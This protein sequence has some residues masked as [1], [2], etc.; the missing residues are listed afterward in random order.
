MKRSMIYAVQDRL[1]RDAWAHCR[2]LVTDPI[3]VG[4]EDVGSPQGGGTKS[5]SGKPLS[6]VQ[7]PGLIWNVADVLR[8]DQARSRLGS[9]TQNK[10]RRAGGVRET[11]G[12]D[13]VRSSNLI[14]Q[15]LD[16]IRAEDWIW[17]PELCLESVDRFRT[18]NAVGSFRRTW[19]ESGCRC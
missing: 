6:Q 7:Q 16:E 14:P 2:N 15:S 4:H 17:H 19:F 9:M 5:S 10:S 8:Q 11:V 18:L 1:P 13:Y 3:V 12:V